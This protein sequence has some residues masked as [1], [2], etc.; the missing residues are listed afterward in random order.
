M[1]YYEW[2]CNHETNTGII[3]PTQHTM[4]WFNWNIISS[5]F[6]LAR[7][8]F[9]SS[10]YDWDKV[11]NMYSINNLLDWGNASES[12]SYVQFYGNISP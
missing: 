9:S 7:L 6:L 10:K 8:F 1:K 4:E 2:R 5:C 12:W 11:T 3:M